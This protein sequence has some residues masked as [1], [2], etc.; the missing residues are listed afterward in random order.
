MEKSNTNYRL[1]VPHRKRVGI[2]LWK[3]ATGSEYRTISHLFGVGL[4]TV[5]NCMQDFC[6]T[7]I[8]TL[9]K[10]DII[11]LDLN[12]LK[13][14]ALYFNRRWRMP[15]CHG[16]I[17]GSHIPIIPPE[18]YPRD[19]VN[20]KGWH[21]IVLQAV[22]DGKGIFWDVCVGYCGSVHDSRVLS[23]SDISG[24]ITDQNLFG[25]H[26]VT[27]AGV[28][29]G[30]YLIGDPAYP[31]KT[32]LMKPYADTGR[33]TPEQQAF[34]YRLISARSQVETAFW[35]LKGGGDASAKRMTAS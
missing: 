24:K 32:R 15:Q 6:N 3:L 2:A 11:T 28:N 31:L 33:L 12:K 26:K 5:F 23:Q 21:S 1:A 8:Q 7:T 20:R 13:Q 4:S 18:E 22:V 27:I 30:H 10:K 16:A 19:Y 35:R 29:V 14:M 25:R 34:N 9:L 17:G